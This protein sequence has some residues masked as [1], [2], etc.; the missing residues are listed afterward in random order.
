MLPSPLSRGVPLP[1]D[2]PVPVHAR[3]FNNCLRL[4][5]SAVRYDIQARFPR[6]RRSLPAAAATPRCPSGPATSDRSPA[7]TRIL[8]RRSCRR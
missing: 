6:F 8:V 7:P 1:N 5:E 2:K 3:H 4:D